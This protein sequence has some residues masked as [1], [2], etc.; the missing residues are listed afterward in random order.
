MSINGWQTLVIVKLD[1]YIKANAE[2]NKQPKYHLKLLEPMQQSSLKKKAKIVNMRGWKFN[3]IIG[4]SVLEE[5]TSRIPF[6]MIFPVK[7]T[8]L[9]QAAVM[10]LGWCSSSARDA[11]LAAA[12]AQLQTLSTDGTFLC[13]VQ[14]G[15]VAAPHAADHAHHEH[16]ILLGQDLQ[17]RHDTHLE[18]QH[19]HQHA[20]NSPHEE[21]LGAQ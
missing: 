18:H 3:Y 8:G 21:E 7:Y 13:R 4:S 17:Q 14:L 12:L 20:R 16:E 10:G 6:A 11:E 2:K 9:A 15:L 19:H 1:P 5:K